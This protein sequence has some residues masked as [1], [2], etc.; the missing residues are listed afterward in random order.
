MELDPH[1]RSLRV[2][3]HVLQG[4]QDAEVHGRLGLLGEATHPVGVDVHRERALPGLRPKSLGQSLVGQEGRVDSP[5]QL[6]QVV[7]RLRR[8]RLELRQHLPGPVGVSSDQA[9][10]QAFLDFQG[11]ELLLRAIM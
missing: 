4:L 3:R 11:H 6:T 8:V 7:Q 10:Q 5:S 9:F 2:L 1:R